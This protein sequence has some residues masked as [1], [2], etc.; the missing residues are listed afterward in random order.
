MD[1]RLFWQNSVY[2]RR[3]REPRSGLEPP[4]CSMQ[5][6]LCRALHE[7]ANLPYLGRFPIS[8]LACVA[9]AVVS[10][11]RGLRVAGSFSNRSTTNYSKTLFTYVLEGP[12]SE[13]RMQYPAYTWPR[14]RCK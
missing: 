5:M 6:M 1:R 13:V 9:F 4:P 10:G 14:T 11:V 3:K 12:F 8:A 7:V 2:L